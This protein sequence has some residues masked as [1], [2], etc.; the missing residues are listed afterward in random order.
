MIHNMP[1]T[2]PQAYVPATKPV[3]RE[4]VFDAC[5]RLQAAGAKVT[6]TA[7][8][9]ALGKRGSMATISPLMRDWRSSLDLLADDEEE[10][11]PPGVKSTDQ[12]GESIVSDDRKPQDDES[13]QRPVDGR[14]ALTVKDYEERRSELTTQVHAQV[15]KYFR[16]LITVERTAAMHAARLEEREAAAKALQQAE[17]AIKEAAAAEIEASVKRERERASDTLAQEKQVASAQRRMWM[18]V[19]AVVGVLVGGGGVYLAYAGDAT[20]RID[21]SRTTVIAAP[22]VMAPVAPAAP[23]TTGTVAP[24][25]GAPPVTADPPKTHESAP[26]SVTD[27]VPPPSVGGGKPVP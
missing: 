6:Q 17:R 9:E 21:D 15:E 23:T 20:K 2:G 18:V 14:M 1:D 11:A 19:A 10:G 24:Q 27:S 7:V 8:R 26:T 4:E 25:A 22:A 13:R 12:D 5:N 3:T 16:E